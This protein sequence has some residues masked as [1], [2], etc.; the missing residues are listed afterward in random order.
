MKKSP[1]KSKKKWGLILITAVLIILAMCFIVFYFELFDIVKYQKGLYSEKKAAYQQSKDF[2]S[3]IPDYKDSAEHLKLAQDELD[4]SD[5]TS[6][7][8]IGEYDNAIEIFTSISGFKDSSDLIL[9]CKYQKGVEQLNN[10]DFTDA[11]NT[12]DE[13]KEYKDA[14]ELISESNYEIGLKFKESGDYMDMLHYLWA[15]G[16]YAD[17]LEIAGD[18]LKNLN[19]CVVGVEFL[20]TFAIKNDGTVLVSGGNPYGEANVDTWQDV[21]SI[22]PA[23]N[24]TIGLKEDG[25]ILNTLDFTNSEELENSEM[26]EEALTYINDMFNFSEFNNIVDIDV[27]G[28]HAVGLKADGTVVATGSN[29]SYYGT[30]FYQESE[31]VHTGQAELSEWYDIISVDAGQFHSVGLKTD[32]TVVAK[33]ANKDWFGQEIGQCEVDDWMNIVAICTGD[34]HTVG[35]K[36]DGTVVA[37]GLNDELYY[38]STNGS[39]YKPVRKQSGQCNVEDWND[40]VAIS[41]GNAHTVG[42]RSDGTVVAAGNNSNRQCNVRS[43]K[44]IVAVYAGAYV[45]VGLKSDGTLMITGL[46]YQGS[47]NVSDFSDIRIPQNQAEAS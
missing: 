32:G 22:S 23:N 44:D 37:T 4:Y 29:D 46:N 24:F 42:L 2:F 35:L 12:L 38:L 25:S 19:N 7:M 33:G 47:R 28:G 27:S 18:Y 39:S 8:D 11:I 16:D 20:N 40:I 5:A 1:K 13:I 26:D 34:F 36:A 14:I 43:W 6:K 45:T 3:Q 31:V 30:S 21:I 17:S 15:A 10:G 9:E 41:A